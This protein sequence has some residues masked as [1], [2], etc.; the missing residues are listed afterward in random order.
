MIQY[1]LTPIRSGTCFEADSVQIIKKGIVRIRRD[2]GRM[3]SAIPL[4]CM[5]RTMMQISNM[6]ASLSELNLTGLA[7]DQMENP[8]GIGADAPRLSWK[9]AAVRRCVL[10]KACRVSVA[11]DPEKLAAGKAD[12]WDSGRLDTDENAVRY[13]GPSLRSATRYYWTVTVWDN[14]GYMAAPAE[15][16]WF[17]TGLL[18]E[19][20]WSAQ[21]ITLGSGE[22][23]APMYRREFSVRGQIDRA[24]AYV[25]A[26]GVYEMEING[27][28]V[29]AD[30]FNPGWTAYTRNQNGNNYVMYQ[31][32]D[33]TGFLQNGQNAVGATTGHGWYSGKLFIGGNNRYGTGSQF[34]CQLEIQYTDGTKQRV[35]T[36][37]SWRVCGNGP[38]RSD[39]FQL[40]ERYDARYERPGWS[41]PGY[42]ASGWQTAVIS[43]YEGSVV[44]QIGP[45]VKEIETFQP[46]R[47]LEPSP[48]VTVFDLGQNIAGFAR[49]RVS[50]PAGTTVKLRFGEMLQADGKLYTDN[51]RSAAATD[52]YTLKGDSAGETYQPR[53][54]FHGFQ[55]VEVTGYPGVPAAG[56]ITGVAL[57]SLQTATGSFSTSHP[58][59]DQ[60]QS[61]V[62]WGQKDNFLSVPTD[63][64][65][66]DERLGYTGDRIDEHGR[67]TLLQ[68]VYARCDYQP[69]RRRLGRRLDAEF[70]HRRG[71]LQRL[72]RQFRLG[73]R[74]GHH[75]LD[76]VH[77]LWG[78][79]VYNG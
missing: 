52:F 21:W 30:Y 3:F 5:G 15:P 29:G 61:N 49:L 6:E 33:V 72:F 77:D 13:A 71:F 45:T 44:P 7:C 35:V 50:G 1:P 16:A 14:E 67:G 12:V 47:V 17:E 46:I 28:R 23:S 68:K 59:I 18:K 74:G 38:I 26:L 56:D 51:L 19:S 65:Q 20:D 60:L 4:F 64:P 42:D 54:T 57:S 69:A 79:P 75:P 39:D 9:M 27:R 48:G 25:T 70:R 62:I 66:R 41:G 2:D 55:Y 10:Q 73:R 63:C 78:R 11:T 34:L 22:S 43:S 53:F 37:E 24:R 40:G 32:Y 31:T 58:L 76:H 8:L 36:D